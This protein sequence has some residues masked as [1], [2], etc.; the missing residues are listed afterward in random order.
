MVSMKFQVYPW[1]SLKEISDTPVK[2]KTDLD[3]TEILIPD[4]IRPN[5]I[6]LKNVSRSRTETG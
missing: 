5:E 4:P 2:K 1:N 6:I 3:W